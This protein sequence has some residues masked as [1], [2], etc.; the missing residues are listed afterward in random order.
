MGKSIKARWEWRSFSVN[1][2]D[3]IIGKLH[4]L[5]LGNHKE[6]RD[7]YVL[8]AQNGVNVKVRSDGVLDV[9]V[10]QESREGGF[11]LWLPAYR[12]RAPFLPSH[13]ARLAAFF[14]IAMPELKRR[15][16]S[17][18]EFFN[19]FVP[20]C[21]GLRHFPVSKV[22]DIYAVDDVIMEV[23]EASLF[24]DQYKTF[25][26]ESEKLESVMTVVRGFELEHDE[27]TNYVQLLKKWADEALD[28]F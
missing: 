26:V 22:R 7:V 18:E 2:M 17:A 23:G 13:L 11:E 25:C 20:S 27:P 28:I 14:E 24:N 19:E 12:C 21:G 9:K 6:N 1:S 4:R 16:Y 15:S 10:M 8:S 5:P 3:S